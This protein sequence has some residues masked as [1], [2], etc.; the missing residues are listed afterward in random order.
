MMIL[1]LYSVQKG[2]KLQD[3]HTEDM[4]FNKGDEIMAKKPGTTQYFKVKS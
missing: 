4:A 1:Q 3:A 2:H